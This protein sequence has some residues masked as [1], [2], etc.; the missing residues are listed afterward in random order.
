M[1]HAYGYSRPAPIEAIPD[2]NVIIS[3]VS[4]FAMR[5]PE[6]RTLAMARH[7]GWAEIAPHMMWRPNLGNQAGL[8]WGLPDIPISQSG[9]DFRF[10]AD[11]NGTGLFFD[12]FW[13]HWSTQAPYY[14]ALSHLAWNPYTDVEALMDDYYLRAFGPAAEDVKAYW[15]LFEKTRMEFVAEH[16]SRQRVF[17]SPGKYTVDVFDQAETH[18]AA[19][20]TKLSDADPKYHRRLTFVRCGLDFSRLVVDTRSSMQQYEASDLKDEDARAKVLANWKRAEAMKAD[21]SSVCD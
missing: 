14:Y 9:E 6:A 11:H 2:D 10:V 15:K 19:A 16:P 18:L 3:S 21:F 13:F 1:L 5:S 4:S 20:A 8:G 17:D 12:L 7:A